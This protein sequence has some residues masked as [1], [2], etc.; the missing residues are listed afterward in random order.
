MAEE[1]DLIVRVAE[2]GDAER[3]AEIDRACFS[4]PWSLDAFR[5]ELGEN[6]VAFYLAGE[7]AGRVEGY[8]GLWWLG[9]EG[10][11]TNVAVHPDFRGNGIATCLLD[12]LIDFCEQEGITA[13]TL[14]VRPSNENA[15]K[16]YEKFAFHKIGRRK[17]YYD[18]NGEDALIMWR[19][20][21]NGM[22]VMDG[23]HVASILKKKG[24]I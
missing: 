13:F 14:E 5:T 15:I 1:N 16:L 22:P 9:D 8:A 23:R 2:S 12:C 20:T 6:R 4:A 11:I 7:I 10:H 21:E 24:K 17:K 3:I 18:D 19:V